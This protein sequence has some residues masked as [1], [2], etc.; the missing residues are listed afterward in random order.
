MP[1]ERSPRPV[2]AARLVTLARRLLDASTLCAIATVAPG[3]RAHI[4]TAYF[5]WNRDLEIVWLSNPGARHS[6]NLRRNPSV[7]IAVHDST[8]AWGDPDRGIQLFGTALESVGRLTQEYE[9]T[10]ATR[11]PGYEGPA[12]GAYRLYRF[13]PRRI[14]VFDEGALGSG[15]VVTASVEARGRLTWQ[16]TE[17]YR[18]DA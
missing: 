11:F 6:R 1:I 16:H 3:G 9:R 10:Y 2:A 15:V 8:Q 5:A 4:N 7:A 12:F 17:T 14:K 18:P 13:R